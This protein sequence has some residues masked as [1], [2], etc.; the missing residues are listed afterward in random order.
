[1]AHSRGCPHD[2]KEC[3]KTS[4]WQIDAWRNGGCIVCG[5]GNRDGM[6]IAHNICWTSLS[7]GEQDDAERVIGIAINGT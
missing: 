6:G 2:C 7:R 4:R 5:L 3:N 1:M